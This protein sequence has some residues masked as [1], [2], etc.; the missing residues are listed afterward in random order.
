V[1]EEL[2]KVVEQ[3]EIQQEMKIDGWLKQT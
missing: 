3:A 1:D 2:S